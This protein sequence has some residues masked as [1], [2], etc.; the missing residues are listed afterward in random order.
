MILIF[1]RIMLTWFSGASSY[2]RPLEILGRVTDP[3]LD[4]FRRFPALRMA[5]M[6]LSPIA[7]LGVLSVLN[8]IFVTLGRYG[9]I[10][11][12]LILAMIL[13]AAWSAASFILGFCIIILILRLIAYLT[14]RDV[15]GS[16]WR[17]IDNLSQPV[18][19]RT[20]R[21]IFRKR[22]VNY[23]TGLL[24]AVGALVLV[25]IGLGIALRVLIN[26]LARL[27]F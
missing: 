4:W 14:N 10:S 6:D 17:I 11:V 1:I 18:I 16:F 8:N 23:M 13:Q 15:Y 22:L 7:A 25:R 19:Y 20:N 5:S 21:I 24:T 2:G 26:M 9:S 3:Y 12:G 27:P